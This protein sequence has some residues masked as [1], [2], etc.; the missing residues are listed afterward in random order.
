LIRHVV[1]SFDA[2]VAVFAG[3]GEEKAAVD[4]VSRAG[5]GSVVSGISLR[6]LIVRLSVVDCLVALDSS[7]SHIAAALGVPVVCLFGPTL[8]QFGGP[9][10]PAVRS[11]Q[12]GVFDCRPCTQ[13]LCIHPGASC[14]DAIMVDVVFKTTA[15]ILASKHATTASA[16]L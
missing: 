2:D 7:S 14:M 13:E 10:G 8:P 11:I 16:V 6:E 5:F 1:G 15:A 12:Q 9:I 3:P 4:V